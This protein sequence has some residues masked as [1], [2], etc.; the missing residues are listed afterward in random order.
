MGT[1]ENFV[2]KPGPLSGACRAHGG[3]LAPSPF[4]VGRMVGHYLCNMKDFKY[5]W[6]TAL[7]ALLLIV[8]HVVR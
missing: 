7:R 4:G 6:C 8:T 3:S 2:R 1:A 5:W